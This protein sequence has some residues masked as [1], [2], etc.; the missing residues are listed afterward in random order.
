MLNIREFCCLRCALGWPRRYVGEFSVKFGSR[1][2]ALPGALTPRTLGAPWRSRTAPALRWR[3]R[4]SARAR[5]E[6]NMH[7][8]G[9][10]KSAQ[11]SCT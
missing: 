6:A 3:V 5:A 7:E 9:R 4:E 8:S 11:E 10:L 1:A 2:P